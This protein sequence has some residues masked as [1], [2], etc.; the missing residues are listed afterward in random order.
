M[1]SKDTQ[2]RLISDN[3]KRPR[4]PNVVDVRRTV[5]SRSP[6]ADLK[7]PM[8]III[9][10]GQDDRFYLSTKSCLILTEMLQTEDAR[11]ILSVECISAIEKFQVIMNSPVRF[12]SQMIEII[13]TYEFTCPFAP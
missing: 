11:A 10:L 1:A 5:S 2:R 4:D 7:C 6:S 9:F 3:K 8:Q 13:F 12:R